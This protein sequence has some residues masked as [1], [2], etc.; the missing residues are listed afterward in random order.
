M[1][2]DSLVNNATRFARQIALPQI[3]EAGQQRLAD[4]HAL[5]IGLGGL[6]SAAALYVANSGVGRLMLN[7]HDQVDAT[8]LPRQILFEENDIGE[9]KTAVTA[10]RLKQL[11]PAANLDTLNIRLPEPALLEAVATTDIV[12]D[13][14]DNFATRGLINRVCKQAGKPLISGAAIRF[15]GQLAL[16]RHDLGNGPCYNCLYSE[17]DENLESCA[18]QGIL[19]PVVGTI[20]CMMATETIKCLLG[21]DSDLNGKLW[22]YDALAGS[23][24]T[25]GIP[26]RDDCPVC[27]KT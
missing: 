16:F 18:G 25:I 14:T 6:G 3:G 10:R 9:W 24:K 20:G 8:N 27:G 17:A 4:S 26:Q 15:E 2:A 11:N 5:I 21:L 22:M 23:S 13:C 12:L 7:D 19:A 1:P